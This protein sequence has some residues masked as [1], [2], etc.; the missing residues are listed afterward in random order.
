M[1]SNIMLLAIST[2]VWTSLMINIPSSFICWS[3]ATDS[4]TTYQLVQLYCIV[5]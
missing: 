4:I 5:L 1:Q 3:Y 2:S